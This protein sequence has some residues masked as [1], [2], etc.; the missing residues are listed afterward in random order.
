MEDG[1]KSGRNHFGIGLGELEGRGAYRRRRALA[2]ANACRR[3][4]QMR[5]TLR[6]QTTKVGLLRDSDSRQ[7][8]LRRPKDDGA[9]PDTLGPFCF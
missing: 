5:L 4:R 1:R 7:H 8:D 2:G 6:Q 3:A 9:T